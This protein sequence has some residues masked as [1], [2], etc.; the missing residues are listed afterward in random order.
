M[1]GFHFIAQVIG[2]TFPNFVKCFFFQRDNQALICSI[3]KIM[4]EHR[5]TTW[6]GAGC[7]YEKNQ[8]GLNY[9]GHGNQ[10]D[11]Q[12]LVVSGMPRLMPGAGV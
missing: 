7:Q 5:K 8:K 3:I 12:G 11:M 10:N 9:Q 2:R 1:P 4:I 6:E